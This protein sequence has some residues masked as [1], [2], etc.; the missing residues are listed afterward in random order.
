VSSLAVFLDRDGVVNRAIHRDGRSY[1]PTAVED[2][3]IF[4]FAADSIQSLKS[5]GYRVIVVT[6]QPD[7][8][9][10]KTPRQVVQQMHQQLR[11]ELPVDDVYACFHTRED[12]C[13]CRKPQP[14]MLLAA[15]EKW[16]IDL[17]GSVMVGDR[18]S[19][20]EAG[21]QAGCKTIFVDYQYQERQPE[22]P[23][24]TVASLDEASRILCGLQQGVSDV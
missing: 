14:G 17:S 12:H 13:S 21:R 23:D 15:A 1:A 19:D 7:V 10:G 8:G 24:F 9:A 20:V 18:W 3:E 5:A 4:P 11:S 6:N 22:Q 2:F 16:S